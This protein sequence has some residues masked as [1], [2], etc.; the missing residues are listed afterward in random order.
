[1]PTAAGII[2]WWHLGTLKRLMPAANSPDSCAILDEILRRVTNT[3]DERR[4]L[5]QSVNGVVGS[6]NSKAKATNRD[7]YTI[8]KGKFEGRDRLSK[9]VLDPAFESFLIQKAHELDQRGGTQP[10]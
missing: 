7:S 3:E 8:L 2:H 4:K 5:G 6:A 1:M 10:F 9:I